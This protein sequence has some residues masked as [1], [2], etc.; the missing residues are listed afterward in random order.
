MCKN[1]GDPHMKNLYLIILAF[2]AMTAAQTYTM[3]RLVNNTKITKFF[4]NAGKKIAQQKNVKKALALTAA[5][6]ASGSIVDIIFN[7]D[8]K[9]FIDKSL[10]NIRKWTIHCENHECNTAIIYSTYELA[11]ELKKE[12]KRLKEWTP[13]S[14]KSPFRGLALVP[15]ILK[16]IAMDIKQTFTKN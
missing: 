12:Q 9:K 4:K 3:N 11:K 6:L 5:T 15:S 1:K 16:A 14:L 8:Y 7:E 2:A 13:W 10:D